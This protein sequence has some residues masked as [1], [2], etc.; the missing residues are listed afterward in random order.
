MLRFSST[1]FLNPPF[2]SALTRPILPH[3]KELL[4]GVWL[5][6]CC[7]SG[8]CI[9]RLCRLYIRVS[10]CCSNVVWVLGG[11]VIKTTPSERRWRVRKLWWW[12]HVSS[13]LSFPLPCFFPSILIP[14]SLGLGSLSVRVLRCVLCHSRSRVWGCMEGGGSVLLVSGLHFVSI[15]EVISINQWACTHIMGRKWL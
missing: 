2:P 6:Y 4:W 8:D 3:P 11:C 15:T 5:R 13:I 7:H 10:L 9:E 1:P 14:S 12:C